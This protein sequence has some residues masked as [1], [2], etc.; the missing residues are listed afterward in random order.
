MCNCDF[1]MKSWIAFGITMAAS[2]FVVS[3]FTNNQNVITFTC[4]PL[5]IL[6]SVGFSSEKNENSN[7]ESR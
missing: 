7:C 2:Y 4:L 3:Q 1:D 6:V 5:A